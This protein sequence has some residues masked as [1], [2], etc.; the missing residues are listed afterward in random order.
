MPQAV[1]DFIE[2]I[3]HSLEGSPPVYE[4]REIR[5]ILDDPAYV[6]ELTRFMAGINDPDSLSDLLSKMR[7]IRR[8][9]E[10]RCEKRKLHKD[11]AVQLGIVGGVGLIG[12][13]IVAAA[14]AAFPPIVLVP[15]FGGAWM[16]FLGLQGATRLDEERHIYEQLAACMTDILD[17][18]R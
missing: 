8:K 5:D 7:R 2:K 11:V 6:A 15:V 17:M 3:E 12:G 10:E 16:A 9:F 13:S 18:V 14:S 4:L 1:A